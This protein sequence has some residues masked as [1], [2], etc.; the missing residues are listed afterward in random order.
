MEDERERLALPRAGARDRTRWVAELE[1]GMVVGPP[2]TLVIG[3]EDLVARIDALEMKVATLEARE[4][5]LTARN[6]LAA[7]IQTLADRVAALEAK[8]ASR[9][10]GDGKR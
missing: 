4:Q 9:W 10:W 7:A 3:D 2:R 6:D 1:P 5:P 8:P